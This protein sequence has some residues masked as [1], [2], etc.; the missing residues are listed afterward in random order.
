MAFNIDVL[1][2]NISG[3][4]DPNTVQGILSFHMTDRTKVSYV[5]RYSEDY[6]ELL[7]DNAR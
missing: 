6:D 3:N 4:C 7:S 1:S 2:L 5:K